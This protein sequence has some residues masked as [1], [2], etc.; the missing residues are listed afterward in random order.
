MG[1]SG[2]TD[3]GVTM[4]C[5]ASN[6]GSLN[7]TMDSTIFLAGYHWYMFILLVIILLMVIY[8][9]LQF[10]FIIDFYADAQ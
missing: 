9:K 3:F 2:N 4:L 8:Q 10:D 7:N 1:A 5:S 6:K